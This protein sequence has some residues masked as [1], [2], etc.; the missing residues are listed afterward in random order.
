MNAWRNMLVKFGAWAVWHITEPFD[1]LLVIKAWVTQR[2]PTGLMTWSVTKIWAAQCVTKTLI[3]RHV[4]KTWIAWRIIKTLI[5][6]P[7]EARCDWISSQTIPGKE[8]RGITLMHNKHARKRTWVELLGEGC[9]M[10]CERLDCEPESIKRKKDMRAG[11]EPCKWYQHLPP[12]PGGD[13]WSR[14]GGGN[15]SSTRLIEEEHVNI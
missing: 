9:N 10:P 3:A 1:C 2:M 15:K 5:T 6:L 11:L 13:D 12:A 14:K 7:L 8:A 4:T